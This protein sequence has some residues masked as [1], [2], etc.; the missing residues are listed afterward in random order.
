MATITADVKP[1]AGG[2]KRV[3]WEQMGD[4]DTGTSVS[5]PSFPDK[6]YQVT[7][8]FGGATD[9][10]QGSNDDTNWCFD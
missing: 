10:L 5:I 8:T 9:T 4:A 3:V 2:T 7:G 1:R 6:T